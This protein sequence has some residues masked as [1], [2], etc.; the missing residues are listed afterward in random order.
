MFSGLFSTG[1]GL[2]RIQ[3]S[4][5]TYVGQFIFA[6]HIYTSSSEYKCHFCDSYTPWNNIFLATF[7]T[8]QVVEVLS[9]CIWLVVQCAHCECC[10]FIVARGKCSAKIGLMPK[11]PSTSLE[12]RTVAFLL[13]HACIMKI[14]LPSGNGFFILLNV[15]CDLFTCARHCHRGGCNFLNS[16]V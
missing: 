9:G 13:P 16:Q 3:F 2:L 5:E 11:A 14:T 1:N 4:H 8:W 7:S 6:R 15:Q 12:L 10:F